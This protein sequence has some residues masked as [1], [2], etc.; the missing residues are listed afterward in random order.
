[1]ATLHELMT[2]MYYEVLQGSTGC[3]LAG[4]T[5]DSREV[6]SGWA[7]VAIPGTKIDGHAFVAQALAQ[8][9]SALVVDRPLD[10]AASLPICCIRVSDTR[11]A[12]GHIAAAFYGHPSRQLRLIGVTGTNGKTTSTYL[13]EAVLQAHGLLPGVIGTV[14]YR[15]AGREQPSVQTTPAAQDIQCLLQQMV[16]AGVSACAMEVSSH[17]LAQHRVWGCQF[18]AALFT[19]LTQ[20]HLDYHQGMSAYYAA[21]AQLFT[22]Y[23]PGVA[24]LNCDD[25][26]GVKL[27]HDTQGPVITYGFSP[28]S[29]VSV[30]QLSMDAY[31][32]TLTVRLRRQACRL[33]SWLVGR[34]NVYNILG[35]LATANGLGLGLEETI[36]GIQ[37]LRSVPGRF[38]PVDSGQPF[39]VLVDYAHTEDALRNVLEAARGITTG[40]VIVVF[41]AGG[42]RDPGKRSRM[43]QVA[44]RSAD[45]T[46]ITS[47]NPRTELPM[48]IIRA[49]EL[50]FREIGHA[51]AYSINEDRRSAIHEAIAL[52][53]PGDVVV[54]AGKGHETC[55]IVGD[56]RF[57]FDDREVARQALCACGYT[58]T[59]TVPQ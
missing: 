8:G 43:G 26:A 31:G 54:I 32:M 44:A 35:I 20:D 6:Q 42:D 45:L 5:A 13:L 41:G 49:I 25:P 51:S 19:N 38:E 21:K 27:L 22:T 58:P 39:S 56:Q 16:D 11:K 33:R 59:S 15:Y 34:H 4:I 7:F 47:D 36:Q 57:P 2:G 23:Q 48:V 12:L 3:S 28:A 55:Q 10:H 9:A 1:M 17:A 29:D 50:G 18:A 14:T 40:R 52:A 53:R 37:H 24:V 30:A 46:V